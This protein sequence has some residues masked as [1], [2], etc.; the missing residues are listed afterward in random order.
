MLAEQAL[1]PVKAA[2]PTW[3]IPPF[4][5]PSHHVVALPN[6]QH[7]EFISGLS[8]RRLRSSHLFLPGNYCQ[9][10]YTASESSYNRTCV[11]GGET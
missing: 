2:L 11:G 8:G 6:T 5:C 3:T 7:S 1:K 9:A 10:S 4:Q